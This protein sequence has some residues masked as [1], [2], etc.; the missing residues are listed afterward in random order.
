[1]PEPMIPTP[2][3]SSTSSVDRVQESYRRLFGAAPA[4]LRAPG[5]VNLIGEHTDYNDGFVLPIAIDFYTYVAAGRRRDRVVHIV[6]ENL[7]EEREFSLDDIAAG[8]RGHWSDYIRGVAAVLQHRGISVEG[9]NLVI[10]SEVPLGAGLSSSAALE[11]SCALAFLGQSNAAMSRIDIARVC[12]QAEHRYAGTLCGVMDQFMACFGKSG[13]ALLLDC[14]SLNFTEL[15]LDTASRI[16]VCNTGVKHALAAGEY[17]RRRQ[18][19]E[20]GVR[21]LQ[22]FIPAIS[23]L[24]DV[25]RAQLEEFKSEVSDRVYRRCRHVI[26]ENIRVQETAAALRSKD[27]ITVGRLL[28]ESHASLRDDYEVSCRELDVMVEIAMQIPGVWGSRMTGGGFG[29]CTVNLIAADAVEDFQREIR[30]K[31]QARVGI[32]PEVYACNAAKGAEQLC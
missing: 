29:G 4:I 6:S 21:T 31:Y 24:R 9:A 30:S 5:R 26:G 15:P 13:H 27:T 23:A 2:K 8:P 14:R 22:K 7:G 20:A 18:D 1:M 32:S 16:V 10:Q 12:Q 28:G 17:N 25:T 19:C 11:V 3:G